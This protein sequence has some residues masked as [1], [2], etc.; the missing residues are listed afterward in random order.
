MQNKLPAKADSK[1]ALLPKQTDHLAKIIEDLSEKKATIG[2]YGLQ[3]AHESMEHMISKHF[4][5]K[6]RDTNASLS[7]FRTDIQLILK[8][9]NAGISGTC[10]PLQRGGKLMP[11]NAYRSQASSLVAHW[12]S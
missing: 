3:M 9:Q 1:K 2:R 8:E 7:M 12:K 6:N 10:L 11:W 5:D 4:V